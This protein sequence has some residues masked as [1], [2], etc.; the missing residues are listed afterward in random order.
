MILS[1]I[2]RH[3]WPEMKIKISAAS[4]L[5]NKRPFYGLNRKW[6]GNYLSNHSENTDYSTFNDAANNLKNSQHFNKVLFSSF[7]T[8][9]NKFNKCAERVVLVTDQALFKL[10]CQKFKNMKE[11]VALKDLTGVSVSPGQDQLVVLHCVGGNDFVVS[12]HGMK[13]EDRIGELV[14]VLASAY[15]R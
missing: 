9:F 15:F 4:L 7:V 3:E 6:E 11:G 10:D 8:K 12:L 14:G 13:Q 1:K 5:L 2:P